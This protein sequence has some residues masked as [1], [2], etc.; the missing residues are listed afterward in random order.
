MSRKRRSTLLLASA[1]VFGGIAASS[2]VSCGGTEQPG[3][4]E[5]EEF[6]SLAITNKA[7]LQAKWTVGADDRKVEIS[8]APETNIQSA[9]LEGKIKVVS[10]D[11]TII[12]AQGVKLKA[13]KA[14]TA[15]ITVSSAKGG[16]KDTVEITVEERVLPTITPI[17][18][19]L[20]SNKS[21][22]GDV[23]SAK[24]EVV[25]IADGGFFIS[26]TKDSFIYIFGGITDN[27]AI[28]DTVFVV[29]GTVDN[30]GGVNQ[31]KNPKEVFKHSEDDI[32]VEHTTT[33]VT[34][35]DFNNIVTDKTKM[36]DVTL[37]V[38]KEFESGKFFWIAEGMNEQTVVYT[39]YID[40]NTLINLEL[41]T[42]DRY[43]MTGLLNGK[44]DHN[45]EL[46]NFT[47][48][49]NFYPST[50]EKVD[51]IPV[52]KVAINS[53]LNELM[54]GQTTILKHTVTPAGAACDITYEIT[55]GA[56]FAEIDSE[57]PYI[58]KA[59][60]PET[61]HKGAKI[62]VVGKSGA[63]TSEAIEITITDK[64]YEPTAISEVYKLDPG[65]TAYFY[66]T[67]LGQEAG[68]KNYGAIFGDGD[69][70]ILCYR[71]EGN[72]LT[73]GKT[74]SVMGTVDEYNGL[75]QVKDATT[76]IN[77]K[78]EPAVV[79]TIELKDLASI[80]TKDTYR[81]VKVSGTITKAPEK[82]KFGSISFEVKIASDDVLSL[83]ADNRYVSENTLT[84]LAAKKVNDQ[85]TFDGNI[86]FKN[87]KVEIRNI[88][89]VDGSDDAQ[90][91]PWTGTLTAGELFK[92]ISGTSYK[93]FNGDHKY[94]DRTW[95]TNQVMKTNDAKYGIGKDPEGKPV[96]AFQFQKEKGKI[97]TNGISLKKVEFTILSKDD[98]SKIP[99][100]VSVGTEKATISS[101]EDFK[102]SK[103]ETNYVK[104]DFKDPTKTYPVFEYK[105]VADFGEKAVSG[106][107][108]IQNLAGAQYCTAISIA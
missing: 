72:G 107:L 94:L 38:L 62:K 97:I 98:Y 83:N 93:V 77:S 99:F 42:N 87:E 11:S 86:S 75:L 17:T 19:L 103:K 89:N 68:S 64:V 73:V 46:Y 54:Q 78:N 33:I 66:G 79:T 50:F 1:L 8:V 40:D 92:D 2:L 91:T 49:V 95:T 44:G 23:R 102:A 41:K 88:H 55:E 69:T 21:K 108:T 74:Y 22:K 70:A 59:K 56:E 81:P 30:Y 48:R 47:N 53:K 16:V 14:G 7:D 101:L 3:P 45:D 9:V 4:V 67:Y 90:I 105:L 82:D 20:D 32:N 60:R 24:G 76:T 28:G 18:E 29:E 61:P 36:I 63:L 85:I 100:E 96:I 80:A 52:T 13:L 26:D 71:L 25:Q 12:S 43:H 104:E 51:S 34:G 5:E 27:L 57:R 37:T 15:T 10:S 35:A 106:N 39:G 6:T 84:L 31:L 58:L 65:K